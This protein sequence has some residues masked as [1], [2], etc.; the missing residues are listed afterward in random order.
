MVIGCGLIMYWWNRLEFDEIMV[1]NIK[2]VVM[3]RLGDIMM[4]IMLSLWVYKFIKFCW[5]MVFFVFFVIVIN[6]MDCVN[7][8]VVLLYMN[9]E[10][11]LLFVELGLIFGVFF[12]IY[13]VC[14]IL[15]GMFVDWFGVKFVF[16]GVVVWWLVFMMVMSFVCGGV[17]LFGLCFLFGVGEVGVF[18]FVMKFVECWFLLIECGFVF[19]IYDCGVC[20]GILIVLLICIVIIIVYGWCVLFIFIGVIG[21]VWVVVWLL[22]VSEF[23]LQ[24]CF[25]NVVEVKYVDQDVFIEKYVLVCIKWGWLFMLCVVWVMLFGFV[26][27]GYVV[28][29]FIM[30]YLIYLVKEC[31]FSLLQFGFYGILLGFVGL[32]GL[33]VGGWIFDCI[34]VS[35]YGL[36]FVCKFCIVV[37]MVLSVMIGLVGFVLQVWFVLLFLLIVF[38]GVLVVML[39]I[40][41]LLVDVFVCGECLVVGMVVG[42]QNCIFNFV[43][44]VS[45]VVIGLLKDVIGLFMFGLILVLIMVIIGCLIYI[46]MFGLICF[47]VFEYVVVD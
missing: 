38:F 47:D 41:V 30:W 14:Q 28:Y 2:V 42:F 27:Q 26:C 18:L 31:G 23:L 44:I 19:G 25:V 6:Y 33:W 3:G 45:L 12:W 43:G 10:L 16:V 24:N 1:L 8:V 39:S 36:N 4:Q 46:F 21:F 9:M 20:G 5:F 32:V 37:G 11:Y 15:V 22:V 35:Y 40:F 34:V 29:F 13:V 7:L 17:L